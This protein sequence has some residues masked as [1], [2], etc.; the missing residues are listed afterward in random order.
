MRIAVEA[1]DE[2]DVFARLGQSNS[3]TTRLP[4]CNLPSI[5]D[6]DSE[7]ENQSQSFIDFRL[8]GGNKATGAARQKGFIQCDDLGNVDD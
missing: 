4:I 7:S 6:G 3:C 8:L 5:G 1:A 2:Q